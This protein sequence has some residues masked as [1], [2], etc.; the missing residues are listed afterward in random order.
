MMKKRLIKHYAA[1]LLAVLSL[2]VSSVAACGC[3]HHQARTETQSPSCHQISHSKE[4]DNLRQKESAQTNQSKALDVSCICFVQATPKA[5]GSVETVKIQKQ[6]AIFTA[7]ID[8]VYGFAL[9]RPPSATRF[10]FSATALS[11][12][13]YNIK[14]PRAP[15]IL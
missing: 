14:L 12:S 5:P 9:A 4:S 7:K 6:A 3:A 13:A 11:D 2:L 10:S 8:V 1:S 15:P